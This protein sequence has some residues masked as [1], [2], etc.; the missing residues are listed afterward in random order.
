MKNKTPFVVLL[1]VL[2]SSGLRG[3]LEFS[4]FVV[5]PKSEL[6]VLRDLE[7]D[8][9][10]GLLNLGQ[11]F[12]G[13]TLIS[14]DSKREVITVEKD[15]NTTE[16][17]LKDSKVKDGSGVVHVSNQSLDFA[18]R[19]I[20]GPPSDH[21]SNVI[22][23]IVVKDDGGLFFDGKKTGMNQLDSLLNNIKE[24][25]GVIWYFYDSPSRQASEVAESA[26]NA[27]LAKGIPIKRFT[28]ES[29]TEYVG[30]FDGKVH[31]L[32]TEK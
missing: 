8:Q 23:R 28:S 2:F 12:R 1:V 7:Q 24:K 27:A 5:L 20:G 31:K 15:G 19:F 29:L 14:F 6:F 32:P 9:T 30:L 18:P 3:E 21:S 17:R 10:S 22:G 16:I 13:Y 26:L 4:A 25:K 11:S